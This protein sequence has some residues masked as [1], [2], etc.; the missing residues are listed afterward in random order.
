M[1]MPKT[2]KELFKFG[3]LQWIKYN[4]PIFF[5]KLTGLWKKSIRASGD[6]ETMTFLDKVY[7]LYKTT[8]P[9]KKPRK[10]SGLEAHFELQKLFQWT[11]P[12]GFS[13]ENELK[14]T[15]V[16]D[17]I[18]HPYLANSKEIIYQDIENSIFDSDLAMANL[19]CP[20]Y[21]RDK[22]EFVFSFEK[23]PPLY[24]DLE[25]FTAAKGVNGK[26]YAFMA[27][28]CNHSLD[29]GLEGIENTMEVLESENIAYHGI[30]RDEKVAKQAKIIEKN[31]IKLGLIAY[32]FGLNAA[33]TPSD[34]PNIV[35]HAKLNE[36]VAAIDF[37]QIDQQ[38]QYCRDEKVDFIIA[39]LHWGLEHEFYPM[40]EQVELGQHLAELGVDAIIGH[41]PHVVQPNEF[42]RTK[43]DPLR[44]V[45]IYY[46]LG[47]LINAFSASYLT[48]SAIAKFTLTKG[49]LKD[50]SRRVYVK[51]A[52]HELVQQKV[53]EKRKTIYLVPT[54]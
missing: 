49:S 33:K 34:Q 31:G 52:D 47:N 12:E 42:Y 50:G 11:L 14:L 30:N 6:I 9:I 45:P 53:D 54:H 32:T 24:Y 51:H 35:N 40:P 23:A 37:T 21:S 1:L 36:G 18:A 7:W 15:S 13:V 39:H 29:F 16:G 4:G 44:V 5:F 20:I 2:P 48:K 17:L 27:T 25:S 43:R 19:E 41:H 26:K 46:S 22:K 8:N 38:L 10:N 3:P 28:A